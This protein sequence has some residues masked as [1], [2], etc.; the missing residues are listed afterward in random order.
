M[1]SLTSRASHDLGDLSSNNNNHLDNTVGDNNTK[2][3]GGEGDNE[4][5]WMS[6]NGFP[7]IGP[8][9]S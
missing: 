8:S 1:W 7:M 3:G 2:L 5:N 6:S 4:M 9:L